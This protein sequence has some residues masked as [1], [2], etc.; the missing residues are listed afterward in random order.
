[1]LDDWEVYLPKFKKVLPEEYRKALV[2]LQQEELEL[3]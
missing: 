3:A 1:M 2:R